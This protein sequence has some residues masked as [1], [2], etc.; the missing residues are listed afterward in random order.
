MCNSFK[1]DI[2]SGGH[3][4]NTTNRSLTSNT[5]DVF[6]LAMYTSSASLDASAT[7]YSATNEITNT[8]G[9][10]YTAGG[11]TLTISQIPSSGGSPSTTAYI[12]FSNTSW[13][14]ATFTANG[15]L[16]YNSSNGNKSVAVLA[17]GG[18]KSVSAGT[19]TIQ[20]PTPG[21]GSSIIQIA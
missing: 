18:D 8:S 15:A 20:F 3:N 21:T 19:F 17:F 4:F 9:A 14:T 5:Q 7:V 13:S 10:A 2:L 1:V 16:I 11:N 6:K 12:N